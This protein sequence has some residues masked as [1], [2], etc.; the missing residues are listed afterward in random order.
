ME[1][2]PVQLLINI[3]NALQTELQ[4]IGLIC[5]P[6]GGLVRLKQRIRAEG[7]CKRITH[8]YALNDQTILKTRGQC[9]IRCGR[10][11]MKAPT[12]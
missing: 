7:N 11:R 4:L 12:N 10:T 3:A 2:T 6:R 5:T 1:S 9:R 8:K